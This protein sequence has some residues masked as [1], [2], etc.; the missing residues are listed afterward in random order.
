MPGA[1]PPGGR[2][3]PM[4]NGKKRASAPLGQPG[5][6]VQATEERFAEITLGKA[7]FQPGLTATG[8]DCE[9]ERMQRDTE[10]LGLAHESV[11]AK[12]VG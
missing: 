5:V 8:K 11:R 6:R 1:G 2:G 3:R 7:Y 4:P 10:D 9:S 12:R